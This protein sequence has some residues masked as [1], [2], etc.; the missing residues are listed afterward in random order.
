LF[1]ERIAGEIENNVGMHVKDC[2]QGKGDAME[3]TLSSVLSNL[4]DI[5][6]CWCDLNNAGRGCGLFGRASPDA[7]CACCVTVCDCD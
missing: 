3:Q 2:I 7:S 4:G 1:K 6:F 5:W